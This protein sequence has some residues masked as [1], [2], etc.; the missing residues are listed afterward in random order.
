MERAVPE[1]WQHADIAHYL[2]A[3]MEVFFPPKGVFPEAPPKWRGF[4]EFLCY[5]RI[6]ELKVET[7]YQHPGV[8]DTKNPF[9]TP[10]CTS[11]STLGWLSGLL[12]RV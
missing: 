3:E 5:V 6:Y 11:H 1:R 7:D 10:S 8:N 2:A 12:R 9:A 4:V